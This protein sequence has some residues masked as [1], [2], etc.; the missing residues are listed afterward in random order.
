MTSTIQTTDRRQESPRQ[1]AEWRHMVE[2]EGW[3]IKA[4][5]ARMHIRPGTIRRALER[6]DTPADVDAAQRQR[7]AVEQTHVRDL[8]AEAD[9]LRLGAI[10]PP[11]SLAPQESVPW[12]RRQALDAHIGPVL[13]SALYR[14]IIL[15]REH[16]GLVANLLHALDVYW[17]GS[18]L[19]L[20]AVDSLMTVALAMAQGGRP[21]G[22]NYSVRTGVLLEG[23]FCIKSGVDSLYDPR[24]KQA[25]GEL[26]WMAR[27][28]P[29]YI[30]FKVLRSSYK[31]WAAFRETLLPA[32]EDLTR[33]KS[34]PGS[35]TWCA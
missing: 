3:P 18:S 11:L 29:E 6:A 27:D 24:A 25:C 34:T 26:E 4:I 8:L 33:R 32:I 23:P 21:N 19:D 5:A 30:E 14:R 12:W 1:R 17:F 2:V 15:A 35:C 16:E 22:F 31:E 7:R 13:Q 20:Q 28:L 9:R 10:W